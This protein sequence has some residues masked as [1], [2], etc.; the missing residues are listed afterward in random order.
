[1]RQIRYLLFIILLLFPISIHA[2]VMVFYRHDP[3]IYEVSH[4]SI[5]IYDRE[6]QK[7]GLIPEISFSG[8]PQD[9]SIIV[10]TPT[11]P[12]LNTVA[13]E[14]FYEAERLTSSVR[15][16][17]GSG[18]LSGDL[19]GG[20]D[21]ELEDSTGID[22][23]N[24][25]SVGIFDTVTLS[26]TDPDALINWLQENEYKY[27]AEDKDIIDYYI[28]RGWVFTAMKI[29]VSSESGAYEDYRYAY[30][31]YNINP[32]LFR[33]SANSLVYPVRLAS[34][35]ASE[36][37]DLVIYVL[38]DSKM[39]FLGARMEYANRID[40]DEFEEILDRFPA[41]GGLMGR[42]RYFTKLKRTFSIMEMDED[43]EIKPAPDNDEFRNVVYFG[44]SPAI[45]FIPLGIVVAF[46]LIF[47][48]LSER[49]KNAQGRVPTSR[50]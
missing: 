33:Y 8:K 48:A 37:T 36:R 1:M 27:S 47:R 23:I 9:F 38:S 7:V 43:I 4:R 39:T 19:F 30:Y 41:F 12:K 17:R 13:R 25:Q 35:N 6:N 45:D 29:D 15:R 11:P 26:A 50:L 46:F 21:W 3:L 40:E 24:E 10:P 34:I 49:K 32:V 5:V 42:H 14:A 2:Q 18:C 16:E 22:I 44:V 31:R 20:D 28:Q